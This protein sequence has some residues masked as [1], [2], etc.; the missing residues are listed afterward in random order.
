MGE[1]GGRGRGVD[2][3]LVFIILCIGVGTGGGGGGGAGFPNILS[4]R[5]Y[6]SY[7]QL[8]LPRRNV[9]YVQ[10]PQNGLASYS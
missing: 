6:Y 8:R 1:G 3:D 10:S 5:V 7:M 9:Y 4:S 2:K